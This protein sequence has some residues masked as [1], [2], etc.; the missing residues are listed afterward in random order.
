[1]KKN[2]ESPK[3]IVEDF[4]V[5]EMVA[6][7]DMTI[8]TGFASQNACFGGNEQRFKVNPL[9]ND[10]RNMEYYEWRTVSDAW[11]GNYN[12]DNNIHTGSTNGM[13]KGAD[14]CFASKWAGGNTCSFDASGM[15]FLSFATTQ[16]SPN[17]D[18]NIQPCSHDTDGVTP[19]QNS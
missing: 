16:N 7:C 13:I 1:M 12:V 8:E 10:T 5:S 3:L 11:E 19:V 18:I 14:Y 9:P 2:Y 6:K 4:T 15:A 17:G